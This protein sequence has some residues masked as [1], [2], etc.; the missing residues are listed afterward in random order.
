MSDDIVNQ[1]ARLAPTIVREDGRGTI[2]GAINEIK[3]LRS[4]VDNLKAEVQR[5]SQIARY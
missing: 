4:E 3:S 2:T 5:L 1:L